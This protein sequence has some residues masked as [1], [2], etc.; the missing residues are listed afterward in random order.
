MRV[1][2]LLCLTLS[3]SSC[4]TTE[5]VTRTEVE[6]LAPPAALLVSRTAPELSCKPTYREVVESL[7][8]HRELLK[9]SNLDKLAMQKWI[10]DNDGF[11]ISE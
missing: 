4:A 5:Y 11:V 6:V 3:L 2:M 10:E 7:L 9:Q 8:M 1:L